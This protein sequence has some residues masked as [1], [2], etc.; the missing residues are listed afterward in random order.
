[1]LLLFPKLILLDLAEL[2]LFVPNAAAVR[3]R[4]EFEGGGS[5]TSRFV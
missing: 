2:P 5:P 3:L 4:G 1:M